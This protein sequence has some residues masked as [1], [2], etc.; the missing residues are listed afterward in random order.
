MNRFIIL[1]G[2][3][4]CL[5]LPVALLAPADSAPSVGREPEPAVVLDVGDVVRVADTNVACSV[6]RR[7]GAK[8]LECVRLGRLAGTYGTRMSERRVV[9]YR[10][11]SASAAQTVF[12]ATQGK[13]RS[14]T[15]SHR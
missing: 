4:A 11:K 2:L 3:V 1:V 15:C 7:S 12:S 6:A 13:A 10:F 8:V 5:G 14:S 9:V